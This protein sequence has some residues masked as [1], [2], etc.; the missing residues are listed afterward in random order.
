MVGVKQDWIELLA[1]PAFIREQTQAG[2]TEWRIHTGVEGGGPR[3]VK[4][5]YWK[6]V[7]R[8]K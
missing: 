1:L 8:K 5:K 6:E 7:Q 3:R 4:V 2:Y